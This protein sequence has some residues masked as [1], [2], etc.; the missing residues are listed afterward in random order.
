MEYLV[1]N[2]H[3]H[4]QKLNVNVLLV[5]AIVAI[6]GNICKKNFEHR[7]WYL[8]PNTDC[9][10]FHLNI[11]FVDSRLIIKTLKFF[12]L[13]YYCCLKVYIRQIYI[14]WCWCRSNEWHLSKT[15]MVTKGMA[16]A[17]P[18]GSRSF[19]YVQGKD[20]S[21]VVLRQSA[22]H[23]KSATLSTNVLHVI[24]L[25]LLCGCLSSTGVC[26]RI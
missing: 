11:I 9:L 1:D 21:L 10:V 3:M 8:L 20:C 24:S 13:L 19:D 4:N 16:A 14:S 5:L 26:P 17:D 7:V 15:G 23:S 6:F 2:Y 25:L 22:H 12:P 18:R